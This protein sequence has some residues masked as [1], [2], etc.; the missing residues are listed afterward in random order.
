VNEV[1]YEKHHTA[2][3]TVF[4]PQRFHKELSCV[5]SLCLC[6]KISGKKNQKDL[7]IWKAEHD[8]FIATLFDKR[9]QTFS[10][11]VR[12]GYSQ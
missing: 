10:V 1:V 12:N 5:S 3:I 8:C 2:E 11:A 6:G 9:N 7:F 4:L